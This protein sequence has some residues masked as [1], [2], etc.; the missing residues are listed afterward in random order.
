[1]PQSFAAGGLPEFSGGQ[2]DAKLWGPWCTILH[3]EHA[4]T[5]VVAVGTL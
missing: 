3:L 1:M 5:E 4:V 2:S